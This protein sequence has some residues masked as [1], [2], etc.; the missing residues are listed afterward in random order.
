[1]RRSSFRARLGEASAGPN[2]RRRQLSKLPPMHRLRPANL[3]AAWWAISTARRTRRLLDARGLDAAL[4][5]PPPPP[6]PP[7]AEIGVRGALRRWQETCLVD[8]IVRQ[9]WE[10]AHGRRRDL[11]IGTTG[12]RD[13]SAHAWLQGDPPRPAGERVGDGAPPS[14]ELAAT[15]FE[16]LLR[17]PA[18]RYRQSPPSR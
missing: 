10:A 14:A 2:G 12:P 5:P 3:R 1:M 18:P 15:E 11:V 9:A 7:E 16:E 6:L 17:R 4:A 13:F 8:A